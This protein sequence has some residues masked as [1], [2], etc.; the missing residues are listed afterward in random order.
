ME[1]PLYQQIVQYLEQGQIPDNANPKRWHNFCKPFQ[2]YQ[3][4]LFKVTKWKQPVKVLQQGETEAIIY[5][6]HNDPLAGH[7]GIQKT[8]KKVQQQYFWPQ[9]YEEIKKY[10]ESCH[11]CQ[12]QAKKKRNNELHP[13]APTASWER[14]GINFVG[15]FKATSKG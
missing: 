12:V 3:Q 4:R 7:F 2:V 14:V 5:L 11:T 8:M 1:R 13:I 15:P 6:Y 10:I 9:M